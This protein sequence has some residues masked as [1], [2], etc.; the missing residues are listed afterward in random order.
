MNIA[1]KLSE[2]GF[3]KL[4][5]ECLICCK[6]SNCI[7]EPFTNGSV[8]HNVLIRSMPKFFQISIIQNRATIGSGS[9]EDKLLVCSVKA[10]ALSQVLLFF[11]CS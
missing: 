1:L 10:G 9:P 11:S 4:F 2:A 8:Y 7:C 6:K 3:P 5:Y